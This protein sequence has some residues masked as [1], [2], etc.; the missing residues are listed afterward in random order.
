MEYS[1][2]YENAQ[3]KIIYLHQFS[4]MIILAASATFR[5]YT[6]TYKVDQLSQRFGCSAEGHSCG[7]SDV[8]SEEM[9]ELGKEKTTDLAV[10]MKFSTLTVR[11]GLLSLFR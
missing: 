9:R 5:E 4:I 3:S 2:C 6:N 7:L 8:H 11:L 10:A 1:S